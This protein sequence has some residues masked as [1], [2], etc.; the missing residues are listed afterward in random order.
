MATVNDFSRM[1]DG[2][3][4]IPKQTFVITTSVFIALALLTALLRLVLKLH[5]E[6]TLHLD[7]FVFLVAI[8]CLIGGTAAIH[9]DLSEVYLATAIS[10]NPP[11]SPA[12]EILDVVVNARRYTDAFHC[13][14]WTSIFATKISSL[15]FFEQ[16]VDGLA[17]VNKWVK[18]YWWGTVVFTIAA[19]A[20]I[21][22]LPFIACPH[23][24]G[25]AALQCCPKPILSYTSTALDTLTTLLILFIPFLLHR[26]RLTATP[27][28]QKAALA[29]LTTLSF[30]A[31]I[32]AI[33]RSIIRMHDTPF[34]ACLTYLEAC[35]AVIA[36]SVTAHTPLFTHPHSHDQRPEGTKLHWRPGTLTNRRRRT[37]SQERLHHHHQHPRTA[38]PPSDNPLPGLSTFI[39]GGTIRTPSR[40]TKTSLTRKESVLRTR[41]VVVEVHYEK[42]MEKGDWDRLASPSWMDEKWRTRRDSESNASGI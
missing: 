11:S 33:T 8:F 18:V 17:L 13:L 32:L 4:Y 29:T 37:E 27:F 14:V 1:V 23:R 10:A 22:P 31:I 3:T 40:L 7:D 42:D 19:W 38:T 30:L 21:L 5:N 15:R 16:F 39:E 9:L 25:A 24:E 2:A 36:L 35:I 12:P 34:Q 20:Y 41:E 28:S 6:L 26:T